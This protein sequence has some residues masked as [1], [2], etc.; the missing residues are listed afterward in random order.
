MRIR[1]FS[2]LGLAGLAVVAGLLLTSSEVRAQ[3]FNQGIG[4]NQFGMGGNSFGMGGNSFGM[5]GNSFGMG[6]NSFGMSGNSFGMSGNSF[7]MSGSGFGLSGSGSQGFLGSSQ[8][9]RPSGNTGLSGRLPGATNSSD[10]FSSYRGDPRASG[11]ATGTTGNRTGNMTGMN[12]RN[13]TGMNQFGNRTGMN[14]FNFGGNMNRFGNMN[15]MGMNG[16]GMNGQNTPQPGYVLHPVIDVPPAPPPSET[17]TRLQNVL[18]H[19]TSLPT[20]KGLNIRMDGDAVVLS[21]TVAT[22]SERTLSEAILRLEPGVYRVRNDI[23]V[24]PAGR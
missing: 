2:R 6:G 4:G 21:G 12:N 3:G 24:K 18:T 22:D 23:Q 11:S 14:G 1:T 19:S 15:N 5:S 20:L 13:M 16:M 9:F 7:G 17:V 10:P 8:G